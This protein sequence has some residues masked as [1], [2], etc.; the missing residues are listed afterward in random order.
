VETE[1]QVMV[2]IGST[3]A[4]L[5]K[6]VKITPNHSAWLFAFGAS[7]CALHLTNMKAFIPMSLPKAYN[8]IISIHVS[9]CRWLFFV[10]QLLYQDGPRG[11]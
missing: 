6:E 11:N 2:V 5:K 1:Q 7:W 9:T 10:R 4:V 8:Y 3:R